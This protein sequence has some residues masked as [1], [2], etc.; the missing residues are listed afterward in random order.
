MQSTIQ[1]LREDLTS[2]KSKAPEA[3]ESDIHVASLD[4]DPATDTNSHNTAQQRVR[5]SLTNP[6]I[7]SERKFNLI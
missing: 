1:L 5:T 4:P 6:G 3:M 7:F 2:L